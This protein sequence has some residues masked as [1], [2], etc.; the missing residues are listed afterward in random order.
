[1]TRLTREWFRKAERDLLVARQAYA[2]RPSVHDAV[3]FHC[4][5][6]AEKYLKGLLNERGIAFPRTHELA[7]LVDLL[8]IEPTVK[9]L[10]APAD[11][12]TRY[13][14]EYRYPGALAT[15]RQATAAL[16]A[17]VGIRAAVRR[18]LGLRPRP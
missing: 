6:C 5:Q 16:N 18:C 10:R 9:T 12:L 1:M 8:A 2:A 3:C 15:R 4:Q 11:G 7:D 14:V 13:A 17:A